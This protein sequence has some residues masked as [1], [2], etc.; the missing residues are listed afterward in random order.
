MKIDSRLIVSMAIGVCAASAAASPD[1]KIYG[2]P[3]GKFQFEHSTTLIACVRTAPSDAIHWEPEDCQGY[4][5]P[6]G[7]ENGNLNT[8]VCLAF[9]RAEL[10]HYGVVTAAAFHVAE[11][12][13]RNDKSACLDPRELLIDDRTAS[14]LQINGEVFLHAERAYGGL[15]H[16]ERQFIYRT[17]H[18]GTCYQLETTVTSSSGGLDLR[19]DEVERIY[20]EELAKVQHRLKRAV[21]TFRFLKK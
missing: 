1:V 14:K 10:D 7:Y 21:D 20:T 4:I 17:F 6:C 12:T 16:M 8:I 9:P 19:D 15:G 11:M 13:D 2:S 3:N 5:D 18:D